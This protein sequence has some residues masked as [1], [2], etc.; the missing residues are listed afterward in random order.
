M[1]IYPVWSYLEVKNMLSSS[2]WTFL[3]LYFV[4]LCFFE[5]EANQNHSFY[6]SPIVWEQVKDYLLP[7][8]HPLKSNLD[9]IF[10]NSRA[11]ADEQSLKAAGF[12]PAHPQPHTGIIVTRH[13]DLR[14]YV[15]KAYLDQHDYHDGKPEHIFWLKRVKGAELIRAAIP[16]HQ[17]MHLFKVPLKWRDMS[18]MTD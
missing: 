2:R 16:V 7:E 14:G 8:T 1:I 12:E 3:L 10:L 15:I 5:I 13:P 6:V 17:Y 9:Q 11:F 4:L 18:N